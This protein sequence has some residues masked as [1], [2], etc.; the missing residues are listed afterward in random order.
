MKNFSNRFRYTL[1]S[2][3]VVVA[4]LLA[5]GCTMVADTTLGSNITPEDQVMVMRHLKF[6]GNKKIYFNAE[7]DRNET[8]DLSEEGKNLIETRH[9]STDS[10]ISSNLVV[11]YMGMRRSDDYG[12]RTASF[13]STM[14]YMN[15][16]DETNGF[17]YMPIFDTMKLVLTIND[18]G[19][20]TLV[21]IRYKVY[22]LL[23]PIAGSAFVKDIYN[24]DDVAYINCELDKMDLYDPDKPVFEFTFPNSELGQ[25][26]STVMIPMERTD[27]TWD[28]VRSLMLIPD[29]YDDPNSGWDGYGR[30]GIDVYTDDAKWV[31]KFYGL[32]I[33][34]ESIPDGKEGAMYALDLKAS[35]MM[36]QGRSRNPQDP[37]MIKD[38]VGMYYYFCDETSSYNTA[39]NKV[40]RNYDKGLT[41]TP[42]L[43]ESK[44][45][46]ENRPTCSTCYVEGMGGPAMEIYFTDDMLDELLA[47][48][49]SGGAEFSKV[50][51][52]QCM[53]SIY[54]KGAEYVWDDTQ[55]FENATDLA[56]MYERAFSRFGTYHIY[57]RYYDTKYA[58]TDY[59]YL[60]EESYGIIDV[61]SGYLDRSRGCYTIN[62]TAYMQELYNCAKNARQSDGSYIFP[63][64]YAIGG[65]NKGNVSRKIYVGAEA[66]SP[67]SF[68]EVALQGMPE[69]ENGNKVSA[70]IQI[71]LTYTLI[72]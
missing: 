12:E 13:A 71:D 17:G 5:G 33:V 2:L 43:N 55:D 21:P 6:R 44:V 62:L 39:V 48:G 72:K 58:V 60:N 19:G 3:F 61:Y 32:Y 27:H 63:S 7:N 70:P 40:V 45:R 46:G 57:D 37:T 15:A 64:P 16:I 66:A 42:T 22:K 38:T 36:L 10:V 29:N 23:K 24:T 68:A 20:D 34:P 35:G 9:Y 49:R 56:K 31:N 67:F 4:S 11:G 25:G 65:N 26:P 8:I 53:L 54:V 30:S 47:L 52:N 1:L 51:I 14:L 59:N 41:K 28:Y 18:Y 69:D 50:G